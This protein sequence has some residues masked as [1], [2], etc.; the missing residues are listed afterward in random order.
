MMQR[1]T[2]DIGVGLGAAICN[3]ERKMLKL[4]ICE[5]DSLCN[6]NY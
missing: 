4:F 6:G 5:D 2:D 3:K 1:G